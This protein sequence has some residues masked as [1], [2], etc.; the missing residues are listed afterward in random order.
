GKSLQVYPNPVAAGDLLN[1]GMANDGSDVRVE[2][3]NA[4]GAVVSV[5]NSTKVAATFK[6]PSVP[7]I[8]TV[9]ITAEG[10]G[11]YCRKLVVR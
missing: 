2:I 3:V 9:R 7:G 6:A 4:L 5:E 1:I 10:K 8:Y 11:T